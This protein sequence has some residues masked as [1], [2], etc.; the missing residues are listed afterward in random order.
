MRGVFQDPDDAQRN[1]GAGLARWDMGWDSGQGQAFQR[2]PFEAPLRLS[3]GTLVSPEE[4]VSHLAPLIVEDRKERIRNVVDNRTYKC[5]DG[6]GLRRD[7]GWVVRDLIRRLVSV[8]VAG[9]AGAQQYGRTIDAMMEIESTGYDSAC[10]GQLFRELAQFSYTRNCCVGQ[11]RK[12]LE[13]GQEM[14]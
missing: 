5:D 1:H 12:Q 3:N 6:L 14:A 10:V 7:D 11:F 8:R 13:P 2:F 9:H 4:V